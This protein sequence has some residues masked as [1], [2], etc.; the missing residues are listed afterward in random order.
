[1][2]IIKNQLNIKLGQFTPK[3]LNV[4]LKKLKQKSSQ[5]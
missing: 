4:L 3:E 5:S 1:M 2:K